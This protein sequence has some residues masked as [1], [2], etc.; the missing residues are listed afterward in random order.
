MEDKLSKYNEDFSENGHTEIY[1]KIVRAGRRT[2]FFDVKAT[3]RNDY[4]ITITE[5]KRQPNDSGGFT[6][7]KHKIFLYSEDFDKI[8]YELL[9]VVNFVNIRIE[10]K[11]EN[12]IFE[13]FELK[14]NQSSN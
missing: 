12:S 13:A 9:D 6:Y 7:E 10:D 8:L 1:S 5:S 3:R 11:D 2:Y 14:K 4:Y